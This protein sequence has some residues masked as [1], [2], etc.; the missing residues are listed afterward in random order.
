MN[1]ADKSIALLDTALRRR[2]D[3]EELMPKSEVLSENVDGIN[4]QKV[5]KKMN[6]RIEILFDRD[7]M[8]GHAYFIDVKTKDELDNVMRNKVIPLLQ[9]YFYDDWKK[10]QIVLGDHESQGGIIG[11]ENTR[12]DNR[13]II[14]NEYDDKKIFGFNYNEIDDA[15]KSKKFVIVNKFTPQAYTKIYGSI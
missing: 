3:F 2:F 1:T 14:S 13:F 15:E 10:I 12:N 6:E 5:L 4:I 9:E 7:H 11:E 8:I